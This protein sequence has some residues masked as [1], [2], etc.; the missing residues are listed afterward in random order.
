[1]N[2][3]ESEV[4]TLE[5]NAADARAERRKAAQA[6]Q[7]TQ[8]VERAQV[9]VGTEFISARTYIDRAVA[10]GF[11]TL[12]LQRVGKRGWYLRNPSSQLTRP[13]NASMGMVDYARVVLG[14]KPAEPEQAT[15]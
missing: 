10:E 15:A 8:R 4:P 5:A 3:D 1:M 2:S 6:K 7:L 12:Y 9:R 11:N 13:L 14:I